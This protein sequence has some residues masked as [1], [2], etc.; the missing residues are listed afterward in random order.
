MDSLTSLSDI[1]DC[2]A[3]VEHLLKE[4][5][6]LEEKAQVSPHTISSA[7]KV[8]ISLEHCYMEMFRKISLRCPSKAPL[9]KLKAICV[10]LPFGL[11]TLQCPHVFWIVFASSPR[12]KRP[13]STLCTVT[14]W[15]RATTTLWTLSDP[16]VWSSGGSVTTSAT[17]PRKRRTSCPNPCR[18]MRA[19]IR[20]GYETRHR[21]RIH[22][23]FPALGSSVT[24]D[25]D[26]PNNPKTLNQSYWRLLN[27]VCVS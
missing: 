12:Q 21:I 6:S 22:V 3:R 16:N 4:L 25:V 2:V 23:R 10:D 11:P 18:Y 9:S 26:C 19:L 13:S 1:G 20:W 14:S 15:S 27:S 5:K 7:V 8:I 24:A 17:R